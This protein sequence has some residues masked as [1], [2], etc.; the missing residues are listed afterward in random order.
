MSEQRQGT[1][2]ALSGAIAVGLF[3]AGAL[4][5]GDQ[6]ALDA[7]GA[8]VASYFAE[9]QDRIQLGCALAAASAPFF[10]WFLATVASQARAAR[11]GGTR[12]GSVAFGCGLVFFALYLADVAALAVAALRPEN[13]AT[14]PE[15]AAALYDFSWM[16]PAMAALL[17]SATLASFALL[18]LRDG[19]VWPR[20]IGWLAVAAAAAYSLRV[21]ALFTTEGAF[22]A[23]GLLGSWI[24]VSA[25]AAWII[26]ASLALA[27]RR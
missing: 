25:L 17:G 27:R 5:L 23:D 1:L 8:E 15:L 19:A 6:P 18:A 4:A 13:M 24:P 9:R 21:G 14:A 7:S 22:A 10:V 11:P 26:A 20:W 16:L 12:A 3:L 2:G